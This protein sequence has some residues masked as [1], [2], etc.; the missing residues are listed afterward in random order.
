MGNN[1][2]E[3]GNYYSTGLHRGFIGLYRERI[4]EKNIETHV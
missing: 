1:G 4:M 2:R 3:H